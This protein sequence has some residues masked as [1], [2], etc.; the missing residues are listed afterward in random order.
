MITTK[1]K[2]NKSHENKHCP[3]SLG[4]PLLF[5][6]QEQNAKE[7]KL[8]LIEPCQAC[9]TKHADESVSCIIYIYMYSLIDIFIY[10]TIIKVYYIL[11]I[12]VS[13]RGK[14]ALFFIVVYIAFER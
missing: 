10:Y 12:F 8:P 4:L 7:V 5:L 9:Y 1:T 6:L 2:E 14:G 11:C 13:R 3:K